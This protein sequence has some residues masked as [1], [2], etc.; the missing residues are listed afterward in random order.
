MRHPEYHLKPFSEFP[1]LTFWFNK[2][3]YVEDRDE[4]E[5]PDFLFI[6]KDEKFGI[7]HW[8]TETVKH[9]F[10]KDTYVEHYNRIIQCEYAKIEK[11][12]DHFV[13]YKDD[14]SC[15]YIDLKG[16]VLK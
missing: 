8:E 14:G 2:P 15:V 1:E 3:D 7:L 11:E 13:C 16:N 6:V 4:T 10:K 9:L 12:E 5:M